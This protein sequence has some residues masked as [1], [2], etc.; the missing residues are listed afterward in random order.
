MYKRWI[1]SGGLREG[2]G[3]HARK[4][5]LVTGRTFGLAMARSDAAFHVTL[6]DQGDEAREHAEGRWVGMGR[7]VAVEGRRTALQ[8]N[9]RI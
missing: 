7:D 1:R 3:G 4:V 8:K 2:D 5:R 9:L 6:K